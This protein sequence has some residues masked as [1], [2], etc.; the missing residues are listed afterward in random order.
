MSFD[1]QIVPTSTGVFDLD[2]LEGHLILEHLH[3]LKES[4]AWINLCVVLEGYAGRAVNIGWDFDSEPHTKVTVGAALHS[5]EG[6]P[7]FSVQDENKLESYAD[8]VFE[9]ALGLINGQ[10]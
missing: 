6:N 3:T 5:G 8:R 9:E 4:R 10:S 2:A 1:F 7:N